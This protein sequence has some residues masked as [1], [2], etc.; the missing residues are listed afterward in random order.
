MKE[1]S[2]EFYLKKVHLKGYKSIKDVE[3]E[4][5]NGLNIIIGKNASGKT[6]FVTF[7]NNTLGGFYKKMINFKSTL[8]F[9]KS[10]VTIEIEDEFNRWK[11]DFP[12][13]DDV[14]IMGFK[15]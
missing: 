13:V 12:Q 11:G 9:N 15:L 8:F 14:L 6:N 4:L 5:E 3:I 1:K 2:E 7:L 10:N